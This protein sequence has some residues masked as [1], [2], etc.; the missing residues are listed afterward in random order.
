MKV[1]DP[2]G[3]TWR[4]SRRWMPWRRKAHLDDWGLTPSHHGGGLGDDPISMI[5]GLVLLILF[6]PLAVLAFI[7]ALEMLLLLL[8]LPFAILGR[9]LFGR[10]W[11]VEVREGWQFA[12][13]FEA[14][15]WSGS[16]RMIEHVAEGLRVGMPPWEA[17]QPRPSHPYQGPPHGQPPP[18]MG[19]PEGQPPPPV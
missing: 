6:I 1:I 14:G 4:V 16:G 15:G 7:V 3:R 9:M 8:L 11:R 18:P 17:A 19:P 10:H 2:Q 12:W 5:I 13:E